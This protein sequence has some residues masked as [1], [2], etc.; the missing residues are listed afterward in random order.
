MDFEWFYRF[1]L[2]ALYAAAIILIAGGAEFGNWIGLRSFRA[3]AEKADV[4]TLASAAL[5]LLALLIAFSF[6]MALS[7]Y[8]RRRDMVLEEANAIGST[9][10]FHPYAAAFGAETYPEL[11][12]RVHRGSGRPGCSLRFA[13]DEEGYRPVAAYSGP[14]IAAGCCRSHGGTPIASPLPVF[15]LL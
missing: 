3:G 9:A 8:E 4:S 7:R 11:I 5:G 14:P 12:A 2:L 13:E 6:S 10:I 15:L 1:D